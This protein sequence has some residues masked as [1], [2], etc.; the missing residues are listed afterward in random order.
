[1]EESFIYLH[2]D[3]GGLDWG[4]ARSRK[5]PCRPGALVP[6]TRINGPVSLFGMTNCGSTVVSETLMAC[7]K[8]SWPVWSASF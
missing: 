2:K 5:V 1:M 8:P 4:E 3:G 7:V 6:P